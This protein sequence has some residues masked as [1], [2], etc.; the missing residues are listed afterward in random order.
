[1]SR[2]L[3]YPIAF[4]LPPL[5]NIE[6]SVSTRLLYLL[7]HPTQEIKSPVKNMLK[8]TFKLREQLMK[9]LKMN[10]QNERK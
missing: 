10:R 3:F 9:I 1:M 6:K 4:L 7:D 8:S 2:S 5:L